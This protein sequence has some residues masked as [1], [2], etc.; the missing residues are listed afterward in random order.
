VPE[1]S[2]EKLKKKT[3]LIKHHHVGWVSCHHGMRVLRSRM[4]GSPP[5]MDGSGQPTRG[6]PS[7]WGLGGASVIY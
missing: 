5:V 3:F 2:E 4:E 6:G 7:V 1:Y